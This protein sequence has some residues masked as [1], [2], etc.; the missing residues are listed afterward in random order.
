MGKFPTSKPVPIRWAA[1]NPPNAK[2][3]PRPNPPCRL[4]N[5]NH[6]QQDQ[7]RLKRGYS[8]PAPARPAAS[9]SR[10]ASQ[11]DQTS[12]QHGSASRP[13]SRQPDQHQPPDVQQVSGLGLG[14]GC[15]NLRT[16]KVCPLS[17]L[18][19]RQPYRHHRP[20][21]LIQMPPMDVLR[22]DEPRHVVAGILDEARLDARQPTRRQPGAM[23]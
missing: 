3:A 1:S 11:Q 7:R 17:V 13:D 5:R 23:N 9:T 2:P 15:A 20:L 16:L 4:K 21:T 22:D 19:R 10:N 18:Q 8:R 12:R 6:S 14:R